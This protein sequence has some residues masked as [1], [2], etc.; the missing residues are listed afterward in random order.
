MRKTNFQ[1][2][3]YFRV[4]STFPF[5]LINLAIVAWNSIELDISIVFLQFSKITNVLLSFCMDVLY[6][7]LFR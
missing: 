1:D 2:N 7:K 4:G 5:V 3:Y 6:V